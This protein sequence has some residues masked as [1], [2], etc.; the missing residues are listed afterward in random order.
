MQ[1]HKVP[2]RPQYMPFWVAISLAVGAFILGHFIWWGPM[3]T[4]HRAML[5]SANT[6]YTKEMSLQQQSYSV[7]AAML[8]LAALALAVDML[9][10]SGYSRSHFTTL[11]LCLWGYAH[12]TWAAL[13]KTT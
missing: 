12:C 2:L 8:L 10:F 1:M 6:P 13:Y 7:G 11:V 4:N 3:Y 9:F 5:A